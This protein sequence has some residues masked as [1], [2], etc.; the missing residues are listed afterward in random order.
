VTRSVKD[1][2]RDATAALGAA[3]IEAPHREARILLAHVLGVDLAGLLLRIPGDLTPE[4][5][6]GFERLIARRAGRVPAAQLLGHREFWSLDVLVTPDTLIPRPESELIIEIALELHRDRG[7]G[8][9]L[10]LGTGTGCLLLAALTEFTGAWGLGLDRSAAAAMVAQRNAGRLGLSDRAAF[11]VGDW[12]EAIAGRFDLI[13][14]NP[15]YIQAVDIAELMPEVRVHEP[16]LA[17]D[18]GADGLDPY[19]ILFPD[20]HRRLTPGGAA[21][22]EFGIG[23]KAA[24]T[25]LAQQAA[26]TVVA[27]RAD[28]AGHPRVMIVH[29]S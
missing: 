12:A 14:C 19:R 10:D 29:S 25:N 26:L 1:A 5:V 6:E 23:Q 2:L 4:E 11:M 21:L 18:G 16:H 7:V 17:L 20:L 3:G 9:I 8:R 22:F 28:L 15:P 24:L 13:L 27:V